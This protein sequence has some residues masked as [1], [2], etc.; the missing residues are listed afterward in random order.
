MNTTSSFSRRRR[1]RRE[2]I[3]RRPPHSPPRPPHPHR[4]IVF[5]WRRSLPRTLPV[6]V[7]HRASRQSW[8]PAPEGGEEKQSRRRRRREEIRRLPRASVAARA[9]NRSC[10]R[11]R[12]EMRS[13]A[14]AG[15]GGRRSGAGRW[16]REEG[17]QAVAMQARCG[18]GCGAHRGEEKETAEHRERG[19]WEIKL[20]IWWLGH[21]HCELRF[22][23]LS[24]HPIRW[25]VF[26]VP[27]F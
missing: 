13:R 25:W 16:W 23:Y 5:R 2:E 24:L 3:W 20:W 1:R 6:H 12:E 17:S 19:S 7:G 10:R 15:S 9:G 11:W 21:A 26:F 27:T 18:R 8:L 4:R 22:L 14:G